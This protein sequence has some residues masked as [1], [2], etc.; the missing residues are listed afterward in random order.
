MVAVRIVSVEA[1][2]LRVP[3]IEPFVIA[4]AT[5]TTTLALAIRVTVERA[6]GERVVGLGEAATLPPVTRETDDE[7]LAVLPHVRASLS[8]QT[9]RSIEDAAPFVDRAAPGMPVLRAAL[10]A[11]TFDALGRARGLSVARL[12]DPTSAATTFSLR[13]DITLPITET[14][15]DAARL[16]AAHAANGFDRFKVKVGKNAEHDLAAL[17]AV[18]A[19]VPSAWLRLDANGGFSAHEALTLLDGLRD[20]RSRVECFEQ[21]C[22]KRD[23][24]GMA[25]VTKHAGLAVI[26]DESIA[27]EADLDAILRAEAAHGINLK[28]VKH[29]GLAS[30]YALGRRAKNEG[31]SLM[32]GAMVETRLGLVAMAHVVWALGGV[33]F[34]DLDTAFLLSDDPFSGGWRA[35]GPEIVLASGAGF[36]VDFS[37]ER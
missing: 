7:I 25:E 10:E 19:R 34:V 22:G 9:I 26:A 15:E 20:D 18:L 6:D 37:A 4:S 21:P 36:G 2:P 32:A 33:E 14:P 23:L 35:R 11:A 16:A 27:T 17:H 29:G 12:L 28:L 24:A 30:A 31:L 13:T 1:R 8:G 5:M 3:L